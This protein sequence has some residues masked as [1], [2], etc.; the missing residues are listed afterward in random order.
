MKNKKT[1]HLAVMVCAALGWWG[2]LY[3]ELT[4]TPETVKV[5]TMDVSG[6][7]IPEASED[8]YDETLYLKLLKAGPENIRFRSKLFEMLKKL[9]EQFT[10]RAG[11][12]IADVVL[13]YK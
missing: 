4:L 11:S 1:W 9:L 6:Q 8:L 2:M 10:D 13:P 3:P 5:I 7:E 12:T